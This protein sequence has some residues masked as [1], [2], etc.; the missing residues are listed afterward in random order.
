MISDFPKAEKEIRK[1]MDVVL[2]ETVKQSAPMFSRTNR[3]PSHEGDK[4]GLLHPDGT[5][6][7]RGLKSFQ[8]QFSIPHKDIPQLKD[9][10]LIN[11]V[12]DMGED[13]AGQIERN[14]FQ[15]MNQSIKRSRNTIPGNPETGPESILKAILKG[16]ER[17]QID[18]E[19]DDRNKPIM[20]TIEPPDVAEKL[21]EKEK[22]L[23]EEEKAEYQK[24]LDVILDKKH[25]EHLEDLESRKLTD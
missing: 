24:K 20:P 22:N 8:S 7:V 15:T 9:T 4:T 16:M 5:H 18:F 13:I 12:T 11:K 23:T 10:E 25:K 6:D 17:I 2:K 1:L 21:K 3:I 14:I 19:D